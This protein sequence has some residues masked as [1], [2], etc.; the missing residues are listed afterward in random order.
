MKILLLSDI[1]A[2]ICALRAIEQAESWDEIWCCGDLTDFGPYPME[3][4]QW[5]RER[6]ARCVLG[7]HDAH[8]LSL[9][10]EDCRRAYDAGE[11]QWAHQNF[12]QLTP[13]AIDYL[14]TLPRMLCLT[15]DGVAYQLQH[16]YDSG[17]GTVQTL[18]QF[19]SFWQG[20]DTMP[21]RRMV[22]GHTH[23]RCAHLLDERTQWLNPGSA[24]YRRPDDPDKR[25][26]YMM[27][28]NGRV[29]FGALSYDRGPLMRKTLEYLRDGH[30]LPGN[31]QDAF[32][33][34]GSAAT[35]RDPLPTVSDIL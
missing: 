16:Q 11:W 1:H 31:L 17:Y 4:I 13:E 3:V 34:F 33:F 27:L 18:D 32:F 7:N 21:V 29:R 23:R 15:A 6:G 30:M 35:T 9:S 12:E 8:V 25:T 2:N 19:D 24:S 26:H 28:E 5:L 14:R 22:F 10:M 20:D